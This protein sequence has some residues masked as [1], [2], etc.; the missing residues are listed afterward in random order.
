[1]TKP[2]RDRQPLGF[3]F[4]VSL[5][6]LFHADRPLQSQSIALSPEYQAALA[7]LNIPVAVPT[8]IPDGFT[9]SQIKINLCPS[10]IPQRGECRE[11]TSYQIIYRNPEN[12]CLMIE[13]IGGGLG[14][15]DSEFHY[16][17]QTALLGEV[18]IRFGEIPG[19]RNTP[20]S[21]QLRTPQPGLY[22]FPATGRSG[23]S[24]YYASRVEEQ[25]YLCGSNTSISPREFEQILQSLV[26]LE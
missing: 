12:T 2:R 26:L 11:G 23:R 14:G 19:D 21:E 24:P 6:S 16:T 25:G 15:P 10:D 7:A 3:I 18:E 1:M 9:L 4:L 22:N 13:A 5:V 20:I 17:T 8:Y